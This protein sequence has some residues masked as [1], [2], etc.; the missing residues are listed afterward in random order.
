MTWLG[1]LCHAAAVSLAAVAGTAAAQEVSHGIGDG[2]LPR[3]I[4]AF[5]A[6]PGRFAFVVQ[7]DLTGGERPD[8]FATAMRQVALL[9]P[10]FVISAGDL[11]EGGGDR[12]ALLAER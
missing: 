7:A 3:K 6:D 10:D 11:I 12:A 8:I 2:P 9:R 5:G 4:E 1:R